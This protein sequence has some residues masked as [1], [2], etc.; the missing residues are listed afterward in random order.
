MRKT[1]A[2]VPDLDLSLVTYHSADDL[3]PFFLSLLRQNFPLQKVRLLI[4][5]H[6]Q[7]ERETAL[8]DDM[9]AVHGHRFNEIVIQQQSNVGYGGGHNRNF[10]A[11]RSDLFL[12][13]N[14]D[15]RY[16]DGSL[17]CL[18]YGTI[19]APAD[20]ALVEARQRPFEHPKFYHPS[21]LETLWCSG[22]CVLARSSALRQVRGFDDA[23]FMYGEDVDLSSRL[24]SAGYRLAFCPWAGVEHAPPQ[25]PKR[26][27]IRRGAIDLALLIGAKFGA[28]REVR[29]ALKLVR[30]EASGVSRHKEAGYARLVPHQRERLVK[31]LSERRNHH[32][33]GPNFFNASIRMAAP[34]PPDFRGRRGWQAA[35]DRNIDREPRRLDCHSFNA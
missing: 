22:C 26:D 29:R 21:T 15:L 18:V 27:L 1:L 5:Q 2:E 8:L 28:R 33:F 35:V 11:S 19:V 30:D 24:R 34:V 31:A 14:V 20:V 7:D 13:S 12:V 9:V 32:C 25:E 23:F 3:E 6:A 17:G 16:L 4:T 10:S